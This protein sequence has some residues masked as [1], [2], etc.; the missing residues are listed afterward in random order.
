MKIQEEKVMQ[1]QGIL[2]EL[3]IDMWMTY[4][5]ETEMNNDP[6]IPIISP[7]EFF[8]TTGAIFTKKGDKI[9]ICSFMDA[10]GIE[11]AG[12]FKRLLETDEKTSFKDRF[13]EVLDEVKPKKIALNYSIRDISADGLSH[14][15]FL[16]ISSLLDEYGFEGEIVSAENII[17]K[18]RGRKTKG[19]I[20]I[21]KKGIEITEKILDDCRSFIKAGVTER[22][23][24]EFCHEKMKEYG[25]KPGWQSEQCPGVQVGPNTIIGHTGPSDLEAKPGDLVTLDFGVMYNEYVTDLQRV[26]YILKDGETKVP[27]EIQ[28]QFEAIQK[29]VR[30]GAEKMVPGG[31]LPIPDKVCRDYAQSQGCQ[32]NRSC[33]GHQVGR[34][35]H[36]GGYLMG[37]EEGRFKGRV[38]GYLEIGNVYTMDQ[39]S[40]TK[41]GKIG[42]EDMGLI[43]ENGCEWLS[44]QQKE[45]YLV[46]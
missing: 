39:G 3:D 33:F 40:R 44:H 6:V 28:R 23:I 2:E 11:R 19:E 38:E 12:I 29:A 35:A 18:L 30:M 7:I 27:D 10:G 8:G 31:Y 14:G 16:F 20:E 43:T 13:F 4:G 21:M 41:W 34:S 25:V 9:V 24:F 45:I 37:P 42:Q 46:K 5:Q 22:Q 32:T 1:V 36:D 15:Q 17:G 26:Y